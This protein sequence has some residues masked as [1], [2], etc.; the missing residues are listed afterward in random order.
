MSNFSRCSPGSI[1]VDISLTLTAFR[2]GPCRAAV[3]DKS[4]ALTADRPAQTVNGVS[5]LLAAFRVC[6]LSLLL[7]VFRV[8]AF[9]CI[10][11]VF[12]PAASCAVF[13]VR[14]WFFVRRRR[15]LLFRLCWRF[16][17]WVPKIEHLFG[18]RGDFN[19]DRFQRLVPRISEN[20]KSLT[21]FDL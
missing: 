6:G 3:N 14:W 18:G 15:L 13:R 12:R 10:R 8:C 1:V 19:F 7:L 2:L 16:F 17:A 5:L 4:L 21:F 20:P 9:S 11:A